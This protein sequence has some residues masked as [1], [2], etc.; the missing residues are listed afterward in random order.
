MHEAVTLRFAFPDDATAIFRLASL[1]SA[2][3][4]TGPLLL[5]EVAGELRAALSLRDGRAVADPLHRT[6]PLLALLRERAAQLT[7]EAPR[8]RARDARAGFG[9]PLRRNA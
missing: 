9:L 2:E 3:P 1:D 5:A 7:A 4:P 6:A 8:V